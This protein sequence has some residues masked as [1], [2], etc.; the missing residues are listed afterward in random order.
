M[1]FR[2]RA[3]AFVLL[4]AAT[5]TL[6][7][8]DT[9]AQAP[10]SPSA[11]PPSSATA[12]ASVSATPAPPPAPAPKASPR[13]DALR[14]KVEH[15]QKLMNGT[16]A[17]SVDART[18]FDIDLDDAE[19]IAVEARRLAAVIDRARRDVE[20]ESLPEPAASGS[21]AP[22]ASS[23]PRPNPPP[24]G[25]PAP[26][27]S[28]APEPAKPSD[29][30]DYQALR[31]TDPALWNARVKLDEARLSFYRLLP[32]DRTKLL[33]AQKA[34][35]DA[36]QSS[37]SEEA[38]AQAD[39][40]AA[41]A[42]KEKQAALEA[43]AH[44]RSEA[45][46]TAHEEH[47]RL[48][49]I[50][51]L[52]AELSKKLTS[53]GDAIRA[54]SDEAL[55]E[56]RKITEAIARQRK[57]TPDPAAMDLAY[58]SLRKR[59]K[60]ARKELGAAVDALASGESG[61]PTAGVDPLGDLPADIDRTKIDAER[62]QIDR[63]AAELH[64]REDA[65][66]HERARLLMA[67]VEL[68]NRARLEMIP[69]LSPAK[70]GDVTG[71][72]PEG[73]DQARSELTQVWLT[74]R[75]HL[76]ATSTW[77]DAIRS[78]D[79]RGESAWA[80]T[81]IAVKWLFPI[82]L[83]ILWRRR[84]D[85]LLESWRSAIREADKKSRGSRGA[86]S[87]IARGLSFFVR[88][89]KPLEWLL[90]LWAAL[91]LLP[92]SMRHLLEVD[93]VATIFTWTLGG[94]LVVNVID[95]LSS[96]DVRG[97]GPA[98]SALQ[99]AHLRL[100]SLRVIGRSVVAVGLIL[101]LSNK[102]VGKGTIYSW[103]LSTCWFGAIPILIF[104]VSWWR[105]VIFERLE[106]IRKKGRVEKWVLSHRD[107]AASFVA[108]VAGGAFMLVTGAWRVLRGWVVTF[109]VTRRVLAYLFRRDMSKKASEGEKVVY[110]WIDADTFAA[111]GPERPSSEIVPSVAD[112]QV[113][114]V[115]ER[116]RAPGGGLFAIVGERGAGKTTLVERIANT[117][118]DLVMFG[119]P[120]GGLSPFKRALNAAMSLEPETDLAET[121]KVLDVR[122]HDN[123]ILV[124]DAHHLILPMMEGLVDFDEVLDLARKSSTDC[125]WVFAIDQVVWRFFER[126]RGSKP[127]FDDVIHLTPWKEEGIV[128]LLIHRS[129]MADVAP[130]FGPLVGALPEDADEIDRLEA[131]QR[132]EAS[133]YRLLWDYA[134]GNPG[135]ALHFWRKS[136]GV[137]PDGGI[138]V[139]LFDAPNPED[140]HGLPDA[141]VF[142]LR[143]IVQL[144]W[145]SY[146][147]IC[148]AT[149][150][151][152]EQVKDALRYGAVKGY[153]ER[154]ADRYHITWAWFRAITRYLQRRHLLAS[155]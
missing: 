150:L 46:R 52:Q 147:H 62:A 49:G 128:R 121:V 153:F 108:A 142:V 10:P 113:K 19:A 115:I 60:E 12:S 24:A 72:G 102:L 77:V 63:I 8:F 69:F 57:G 14:E 37:K 42:E 148:E 20:A 133:Y 139:R 120:A 25:T 80:A 154:D 16:L 85:G 23:A 118:P 78:G 71:F 4:L 92:V 127:L 30:A 143:A 109:T 116:I 130:S 141:T 28:A 152:P 138:H 41:T 90:L 76:Y 81:L 54:R 64:T 5:L 124:D 13:V 104:I 6:V 106:L 70:R 35:R 131:L 96:D 122:N 149:A 155:R 87:P 136:L 97:P 59:L 75:H 82:V 137:A 73:I 99:T 94:A 79:G 2:W 93:L 51:K 7:P 31:K 129:E 74:L 43:A 100:R 1:S 144:G 11:S 32:E 39:Q 111:L 114:Q 55:L 134:D 119:C 56:R 40:E 105:P 135:V 33:T 86:T 22:S 84:A 45:E 68:L 15:I 53:D 65:L 17:L 112:A 126:A 89:R 125:T 88:V 140:L 50:T 101:A 34:R 48:L 132:T 58:V 98:P 110:T 151:P 67:E 146:E 117:S 3:S 123:A 36:D 9:R 61:V 38:I 26:S 83:F 21:A 103:V 18:L 47:A 66:G 91:W 95:A 107:G 44:A 145:A 29:G 27:T